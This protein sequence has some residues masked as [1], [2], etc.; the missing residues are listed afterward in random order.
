[1]TDPKSVRAE[2]IE[3]NR[4]FLPEWAVQRATDEHRYATAQT[5]SHHAA[6]RRT[7]S[8]L[9]VPRTCA[10]VDAAGVHFG[11]SLAA[12]PLC[13]GSGIEWVL[14]AEEET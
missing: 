11:W 7:L 10:N 9:L 6:M 14:R 13:C 8:A 1:M 5:F 12:C 3:S 2:P 4:T